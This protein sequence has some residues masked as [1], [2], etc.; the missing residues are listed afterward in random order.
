MTD[1]PV[2]C[3]DPQCS[4]KAVV[5]SVEQGEGWTNTEVACVKCGWRGCWSEVVPVVRLDGSRSGTDG[6]G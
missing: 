1:N 3:L 5:L 2:A 6:R 4:T